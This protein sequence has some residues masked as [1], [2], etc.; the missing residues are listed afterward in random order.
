MIRIRTRPIGTTQ[1]SAIVVRDGACIGA[2]T[3]YTRSIA[4]RYAVKRA[5]ANIRERRYAS[6]ERVA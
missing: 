5:R 6:D 2:A 3:T 4:V 1:Y